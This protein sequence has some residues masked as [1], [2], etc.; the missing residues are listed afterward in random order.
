MSAGR[1]F[2]EFLRLGLTSFGGPVAH[3]GYF[4]GRFVRRLGWLDETAFADLVALCQFLPGPASSQLGMAIGQEKAGSRGALAAFVGFTLPSAVLMAL[5]ASGFVAGG[6]LLDRGLLSGLVIVAVAVVAEAVRGMAL[7]LARGALG[8]TIA[9]AATAVALLFPG[10][11]TQIGILAAGG[12]AGL[13]LATAAPAPS[14]PS[15]PHGLSRGAGGALLIVFGGL[16]VGLPALAAATGQP[17]LAFLAGLY[18]AGAL[19]FGGGHVVLPLLQDAM[20]G[21]GFVSEP[22][23]VAGYGAA[24]AMPGPLFSFSAWLGVMAGLP[25]PFWGAV[26]AVLALFA[27]AF[28]LVVG[29]MPFWRELRRVAPVRRALVGVNAAVVGVLAAA[30]YDPVFTTAI[31]GWRDLALAIACYGLLAVLRLPSW[32][33]V[34]FA[35]GGGWAIATLTGP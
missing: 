28:L 2:I 35:A 26:L 15:S 16:L 32:M 5:L 17:M 6:A 22:A 7:S 23:F 30:L 34:L 31:H 33:V 19:V 10:S 29:A 27:P 11:L 25:G 21:P 8:A 4:R 18:R 14:S 20:V 12:V 24:Q 1:V 3:I 9:L 13:M